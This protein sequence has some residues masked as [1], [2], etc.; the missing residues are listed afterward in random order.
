M[1]RSIKQNGE[2]GYKVSVPKSVVEE[3]G[4]KPGERLYCSYG[5]EGSLVYRRIHNPGWIVL[6]QY[7]LL[8]VGYETFLTLPVR[9]VQTFRLEL[10]SKMEVSCPERGIIMM[11]RSAKGSKA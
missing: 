5:N 9:F 4:F 3:A 2:R 11:Q 6:G 1:E 8:Q 10:G 7:S